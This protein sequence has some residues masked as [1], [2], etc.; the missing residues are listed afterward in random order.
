[1]G[2]V[3]KRVSGRLRKLKKEKG[4]KVL[5]DGKKFGGISLL[6]DYKTIMGYPFDRTH[7]NLIKMRKAVGAVL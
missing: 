4:G 3:Q 7:Y 1:M 2:H 5:N 6:I